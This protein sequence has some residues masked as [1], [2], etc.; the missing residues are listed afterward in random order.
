M[1]NETLICFW[2]IIAEWLVIGKVG[3]ERFHVAKDG[4]TKLPMGPSIPFDIYYVH[5]AVVHPAGEYVYLLAVRTPI[6]QIRSLLLV[7]DVKDSEW[8]TLPSLIADRIATT[9]FIVGDILYVV[10]GVTADQEKYF[11]DMECLKVRSKKAE[12]KKCTP[13]LPEKRAGMASCVA[14]GSVWIT[15]GTVGDQQTSVLYHWTPGKV[16]WEKMA[17]MKFARADHVMTTDGQLL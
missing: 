16:K 11:S 5:L 9:T 7:Y 13:S 4:I 1:F 10:G 12:W 2:L 17:G 14:N 8:S 15:G 3:V 6:Y